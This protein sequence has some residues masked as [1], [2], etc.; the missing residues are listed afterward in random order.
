MDKPLNADDLLR[1]WQNLIAS[2]YFSSLNFEIVQAPSG[3]S[4][5]II[6]YQL[7]G[8]QKMKIGGRADNER[9]AQLGV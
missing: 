3:N 7:I 1:S 4:K 8:M 6:D 9:G 2:G 5:V